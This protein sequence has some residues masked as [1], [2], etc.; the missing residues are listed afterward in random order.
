MEDDIF[1]L[2][3]DRGAVSAVSVIWDLWLA[4]LKR[5]LQLLYSKY[6]KACIINSEYADPANFE[7]VLDIF[8]TIDL[9]SARSVIHAPRIQ[10][11]DFLTCHLSH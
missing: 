11:L 1:T 5:W 3:R 8:S 7:Q 6:S 10:L 9:A 4:P 2:A